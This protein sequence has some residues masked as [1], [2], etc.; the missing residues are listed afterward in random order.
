MIGTTW[1]FWPGNEIDVL[2]VYHCGNSTEEARSR[3]CRL[4]SMIFGWVPNECYYEELSEQYRPFEDRKWYLDPSA[5]ELADPARLIAGEV[6]IAY[7]TAYHTEHC[8]F[9]WR[10]LAY[11]IENRISLIDTKSLKLEHSDHCADTLTRFKEKPNQIVKTKL[12]FYKCQRLP[13]A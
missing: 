12:G 7:G 5:K 10:K 8:L 6:P 2:E 3:G 1:L 9:L 11:A 4:E 13:W